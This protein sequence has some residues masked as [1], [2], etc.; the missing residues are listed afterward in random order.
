MSCEG[1]AI[2]T[3]ASRWR[4]VAEEEDEFDVDCGAVLVSATRARVGAVHIPRGSPRRT[5]SI[6][7]PTFVL[8]RLRDENSI[9]KRRLMEALVCEKMGSVHALTHWS[10]REFRFR[11]N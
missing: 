3:L 6:D 2:G 8:R 9:L 5:R 7:D 4:A 11:S 1:D 10:G